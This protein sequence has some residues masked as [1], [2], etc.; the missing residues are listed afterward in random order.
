M[1][2]AR[3]DRPDFYFGNYQ[4]TFAE[5][6]A[7]DPVHW[8]SEIGMWVVTRHAHIKEVTTDPATYSN[9]YGVTVGAQA[10]A[11]ELLRAEPPTDEAGR[12]WRTAEL[13]QQVGRRSS[14]EAD[15]DNLQSL[16]PP[17]HARIRRIF[18]QSFTPRTLR[19]LEDRVRQ[20][21]RQVLTEIR[22]GE[23]G[24][25]VDLL[26][27][28]VPIYVIAEVLGVAKE[29]RDDFRRWSDAV[30]SNVEPKD[31]E[32]RRRDTEQLKEMFGYFREQVALR[33]S[34]PQDDL[35][36]L[37]VQ[38]DVDG[39][40]LADPVVET[41]AKLIM[42]AGNETVRSA[43]SATALALAEHPDQ[44]QQLV[45]DPGLIGDAVDEFLRW[46]T[47]VRV[48]CRT[49]VRDVT[50]GEKRLSRG[51]YLALSFVSA[52]RDE[53]AWERPD[54]FDVTRK[55][56]PGHVTFGHGPHICLGQSLA[57]LELKVVFEELLARF[58]RYALAGHVTGTPST[59]VDAIS[60]MP[61]V[62]Q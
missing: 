8:Q 16:D 44:R 19:S 11:R 20:L 45:D 59:L 26:A 55:V 12:A 37:M 54:V 3:I 40:P 52:N 17:A 31:D 9:N 7:A 24:D 50:L 47:P 23:R 2:D 6:R 32:A 53:A 58:P 1:S 56:A 61:V 43:I 42:S 35:L 15:I 29:D 21:T 51:D 57:R 41:L 34:H 18:A 5:L 30:I 38:A 33:R 27:A 25:L 14:A 28:P 39:R 13:R 60:A 10:I 46:V 4:R 49:A 48:F 22:P 36:T 62:F